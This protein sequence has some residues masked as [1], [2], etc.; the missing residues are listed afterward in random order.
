MRVIGIVLIL[1]GVLSL[2][3][4]GFTY[5]KEHKVLDVGPLQ[6]SV[7]EKKTVPISP[8]LGGL[9][10]AAGLVMVLADRRKT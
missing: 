4:K 9:A 5:T 6:A 3:Y 7:D 2:A 10:L 1:V 8:L